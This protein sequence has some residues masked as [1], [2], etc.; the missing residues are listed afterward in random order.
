MTH[1]AVSDVDGQRYRYA[2]RLSRGGP[3]LAGA[4]TDR[5]RVWNEDWTA[6]LDERGRHVLRALERKGRRR[7]RARAGQAARRQRPGRHQP[8]GRTGGQRVSLLLADANADHGRHH[9]RR[10]TRRRQ[11]R[12]LDGSRIRHHV[13]RTRAAGLGLAVDSA[14]RRPGAD[15][16][17]TPARRRQPRSAIERHARRAGRTRDA[18]EPVRLHPDRRQQNLP[19]A[20][21]RRV[22]ARLDGRASRRSSWSSR[23]RPRSRIRNCRSS[24]RAASPTGKG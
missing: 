24:D 19:G 8:E 17:P 9:H 20:Q 7:S 13:S 15:A 12:E 2:E 23:S 3:G 16:V 1:L 22:P 18:S 10:P 11:R 5:Y 14:R 6:S 4:A 21:R